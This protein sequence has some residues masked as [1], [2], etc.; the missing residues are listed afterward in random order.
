MTYIRPRLNDFFGIPLSQEHADFAIPF[1]DED[2]PLYLDP[3]LLW[4]SPS[5]QD[6]ALHSILINSFNHLGYL[7]NK[8]N[9]TEAVNMLIIMSECSE[10]G[11]GSGK[12]KKGAKISKITA[13]EILNLF[14]TIP[15]AR[16]NGFTHFEVIQLYINSI[17][18]DRISDI[19][20]SLLKSFLIDYTQQQCYKYNIPMT[21]FNDFSIYE[22]KANCFKSEQLLL[23]YSPT[24]NSPII[25]TPKRWLRYIPWINYEDYFTN[26][27]V[28][29]GQE[30][31][32]D[33]PE[34]LAY[35]R[36]NYDV[37]ESYIKSKER[38]QAD[39][40]ND[41]LFKQIPIVSAKKTLS[42][43][44]NLPTG[45]DDNADQ[46]FE[47]CSSKLL[48]S[49]LYPHLDFAQTQSRIE[50]GTQIR[51]LIFYNN[52]E[53]PFLKDIYHE[54]DCKQIVIEMKNVKEISRD[55]INQLNRYLTQQ[56][57]RFGILLTRNSIKKSLF[58][59]TIDLWA[60]QRKCILCLTDEDIKFMVDVYESKQRD[61]I[62]V[63]K[64]KYVEFIRACPA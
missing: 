10:V 47:N 33:K 49:L 63:L 26:G 32:L 1:L 59:N 9:E 42:S 14:K 28:K 16:I 11:L 17:S 43:I 62:D 27:F 58:K 64:K 4:K 38:V 7:Y 6:N 20:C 37:I 36:N 12:T 2:I 35:N 8:G 19:G 54:Y 39:C 25:F 55:H 61:P 48:A 57:G 56:F 24:N 50:S 51:D 46:K 44:L 60:G 41:P 5:L 22:H 18:K 40:K 30:D 52:C 34:I 13:N 29:E 3:F 53:H 15:Q 45:K 23:P 21:D 31:K